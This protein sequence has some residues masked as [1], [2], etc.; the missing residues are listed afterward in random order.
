MSHN[1][2]TRTDDQTMTDEEVDKAIEST[3]VK[4]PTEAHIDGDKSE[5]H[6][7]F[8]T[9]HL[10]PQTPEHLR[11]VVENYLRSKGVTDYKI[12]DEVANAK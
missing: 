5:V 4:V 2:C 8:D 11:F 3:D 7:I 12:G 9:S 6:V 10:S 1:E